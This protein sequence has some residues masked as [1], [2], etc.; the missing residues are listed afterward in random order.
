MKKFLLVPPIILLIV[1]SWLL[2]KPQTAPI[3]HE[4]PP[5]VQIPPE[6][7]KFP[8][9][10]VNQLVELTNAE[11]IKAGLGALAVSSTLN[12]SAADK[13]ADMQVR[14]YWSHDTP[15][16]Q[17]FDTFFYNRWGLGQVGENL[18]KSRYRPDDA[19]QAWMDSPTHKANILGPYTR[20]GFAVC[21]GPQRHLIVQHL[22]QY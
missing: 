16:G 5:T 2:F 13:C 11:R 21:E 18:V 9:D 10:A 15:D 22:S 4:Q 19:V 12:Q 20:A 7:E 17:S 6:S 8:L 3:T 1:G 14:N